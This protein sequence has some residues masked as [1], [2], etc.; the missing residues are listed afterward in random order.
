[1]S[2][3]THAEQKDY[4]CQITGILKEYKDEMI[5]K[6]TDPTQRITNLEKPFAS[7]A[8]PTPPP[9]SPAKARRSPGAAGI[10]PVPA[11]FTPAP[12]PPWPLSKRWC[13]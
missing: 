9:P 5:A 3:F 11:W 13:I 10:L 12:P 6:D 1:M 7:S 8:R 4:T 2:D